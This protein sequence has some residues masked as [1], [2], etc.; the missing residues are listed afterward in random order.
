MILCHGTSSAYLAEILKH[1]IQPR[2][3]RENGI[4]N[5]D[6]DLMGVDITSHPD[7]V[8]LS[9]SFGVIYGINTEAARQGEGAEERLT[10]ENLVGEIAV[11]EVSVP[12]DSLYPDEDALSHAQQSPDEPTVKDFG[13]GMQMFDGSFTPIWKG[14]L[15]DHK[16]LYKFSLKS[17]GTCTHL[18]TIPV[19]RIT[20][21][22]RVR[23]DAELIL[24][25][26]QSICAANYQYLGRGYEA[27]I[28]ELFDREF[29]ADHVI[30]S[31][32]LNDRDEM[33]RQLQIDS[34]EFTPNYD[35]LRFT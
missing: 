35:H 6:K 10:D 23:L 8:Y 16:H 19:E 12:E 26:D 33:E 20:R 22:M 5:Y 18:G 2:G 3:I 34:E 9:K 1:G 13:G 25:F 28:G 29:L 14:R 11:I 21:Y 24:N 27:K 17:M 15:L 32:T 30:E 31:V 4:S 7:M